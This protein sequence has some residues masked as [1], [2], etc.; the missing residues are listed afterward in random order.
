MELCDVDYRRLA[1]QQERPSSPLEAL[2][3][4]RGGSMFDDF[5]NEDFFGRGDGSTDVGQPR[6]GQT[7]IP[8]RRGAAR[9]QSAA[10][11]ITER[12]ST[13]ADEILQKA[14]REAAEAG[15]RE[16]DT[17][18]LLLAL[19]E[20]GVVRTILSQFK[21]SPDE[22]RQQIEQETRRVDGA[23]EEGAEIG[24][25]PRVKDALSRGFR[26]SAEFGHSYVGP[27]HLLIGLAEE[28]E[29]LA[30][31]ILRRY[32]LTPQAIRQQVTKVV[33]RGAE[34]GRVDAP[35]N[36]PNLDKYGRDLTKLAREGRLDP[37]V[38]RAK[39]IETTIEVLARR[40]KTI[41]C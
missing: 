15:R 5:F 3:G 16:V 31:D 11:D 35:T 8:G 10:T 34:E 26:A 23:Q 27:E 40:K 18:H 17:E 38:G 14:A 24:V 2:F 7:S 9:G 29:G 6:G 20:S 41:R 13:Q 37:V 21:V 28:G 1:R 19:T 22:L 30:A 32:G 12:L 36:T 33:G 39:E 25:S 4:R